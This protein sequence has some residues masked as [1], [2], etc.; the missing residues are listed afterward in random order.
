MATKPQKQK[1]RSGDQRRI[2]VRVDVV[3]YVLVAVVS[4]LAVSSAIMPGQV[5]LALIGTLTSTLIAVLGGWLTFMRLTQSG[6]HHEPEELDEPED[7]P[8]DISAG[9]ETE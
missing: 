7:E 3:I 9:N 5:E 2:V 8:P 4:I 1:R 6:N